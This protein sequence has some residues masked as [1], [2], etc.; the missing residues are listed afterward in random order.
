MF[1]SLKGIM[2]L[3]KRQL[4]VLNHVVV[5]GQEWA[6]NAKQESHILDKIANHESSYDEAV[7]KGNY[8]NRKQRDEEITRLEQEKYDNASWDVK[9]QREYPRISEL[10][11]ALYDEDDKAEIIKRRAEVK[12][13]YPKE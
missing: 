2:I 4:D 11:V 13:K 9:R 12:L 3:T 8:K 7:A 10:V 1:I 5:N 6:D